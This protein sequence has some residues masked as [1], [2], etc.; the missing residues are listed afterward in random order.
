MVL[1]SPKRDEEVEKRATM[2]LR[3][4]SEL[5]FHLKEMPKYE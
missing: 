5:E 4:L 1:G 2:F 3:A